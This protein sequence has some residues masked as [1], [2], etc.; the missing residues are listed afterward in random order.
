MYSYKKKEK[1]ATQTHTSHSHTYISYNIYERRKYY[2]RGR[3]SREV[4]TWEMTFGAHTCTVLTP[5]PFYPPL[6]LT[7]SLSLS[8]SHGLP[9]RVSVMLRRCTLR[10]NPFYLSLSLSLYMYLSIYLS[11]YISVSVSSSRV[12]AIHSSSDANVF[13]DVYYPVCFTL[14]FPY[15]AVY[16]HTDASDSMC[17]FVRPAYLPPSLFTI[18]FHIVFNLSFTPT[19]QQIPNFPLS[20]NGMEN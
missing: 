4:D 10:I 16:D 12:T 8:L 15:H 20:P 18:L 2:W 11:V 9:H 5:D 14:N 13:E 3:I 19:L 17:L 6:S 7:H 1:R